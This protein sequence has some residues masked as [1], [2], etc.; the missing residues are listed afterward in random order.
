MALY[1]LLNFSLLLIILLV[2][3]FISP[4]YIFSNL[5]F[6]STMK[7]VTAVISVDHNLATLKTKH[8]CQGPGGELIGYKGPPC[9]H[10]AIS[11]LPDAAH[12]A[13][14]GV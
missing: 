6:S 5:S 12:N 10:E 9:K 1:Y 8:K 7:L 14:R 3:I 4:G 11:L 2:F 13:Q